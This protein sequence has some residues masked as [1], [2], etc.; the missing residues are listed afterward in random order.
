MAGLVS[1][2]NDNDGARIPGGTRSFIVDCR[3]PPRR[4]SHPIGHDFRGDNL[5]ISPARS[6]LRQATRLQ[7]ALLPYLRI[8]SV[9]PIHFYSVLRNEILEGDF[10]LKYLPKNGKVGPPTP[11]DED[12]LF[13]WSYNLPTYGET[14]PSKPLGHVYKQRATRSVSLSGITFLPK[15]AMELLDR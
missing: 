11:R 10:E 13:L 9:N 7:S 8:S 14:L 15:Q 5:Y 2:V 6:Y 4:L 12:T 3:T 1:A